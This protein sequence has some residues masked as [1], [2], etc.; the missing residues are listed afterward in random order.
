M[1][2]AA[3]ACLAV[4]L[5]SFA[6]SLQVGFLLDDFLHIDYIYRALHGSPD[7]FL[8][9]FYGNWANSPLM[10][11][12][13]PLV[14]LS[15]F[16]DYLLWGTNSF[17]FHLT[18]TLLYWACSLMVGLIALELTGMRGNRLAAAA[19]F[20]AALLFSVYPLHVESVSWVIG[21]VDLLCTFFTL[22]SV[23]CYFR[24][25][26]LRE[27][28]LF[29]I[30][31]VS[32]I[33]AVLSKEPAVVLPAV[34]TAAEFILAPFWQ[35]EVVSEFRP[36]VKT[37]R[38]TGLLS[39]W[40]VLGIYFMLRLSFLGTLVG[41]YGGSALASLKQV[42]ERGTIERILFASNLDLVKRFNYWDLQLELD[43]VLKLCYIAI[44]SIGC[45]RLL[46]G[47]A[48]RRI[49][50]FLL[51]WLLLSVLPAMQI[52]QISPNLVGSRLFFM[53][54]AP[55]T[56]LLAFLALPA[57][58]IVKK[59]Y[60]KVLSA[61][62]A[63]LLFTVLSIWSY[64]LQFDQYSWVLAHKSM[65]KLIDDV[66]RNLRQVTQDKSILFLNLPSDCSGAGLVSRA[67]Y[68]RF[69]F[70]K[71]FDDQVDTKRLVVLEAPAG[72]PDYNYS[73]VLRLDLAKGKFGR[74]L[75]WNENAGTSLCGQIFEW[76]PVSMPVIGDSQ[77]VSGAP[78][79]LY[80]YSMPGTD[81]PSDAQ[82]FEAQF[83]PVSPT[84]GK[85]WTAEEAGGRSFEKSANGALLISPGDRDLYLLFKNEQSISA[86]ELDR[87]LLDLSAR[88]KADLAFGFFWIDQSAEGEHF[89]LIDG[90][91]AA[92][93][94]K[95]EIKLGTNKRWAI[96]GQLKAFGLKIPRGDYELEFRGL[97]LCK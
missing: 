25:R 71:P 36:R 31:L 74:V 18:N 70:Q 2:F 68:L 20:W 81:S 13:R 66:K 53:A 41:G 79:N 23:F 62:G 95:T 59:Q 67:D 63:I 10:L 91:K 87:A 77:C 43:G 51:A 19:P 26:L 8:H 32:F 21:R 78:E 60:A 30:S 15:L 54:S 50:L 17:G 7:D 76:K 11:S 42:F 64:W 96:S 49:V 45:L 55:F 28:Y 39:F 82:K 86:L 29:Q 46:L 5:F 6:P 35:D 89:N 4:S 1:I 9:N 92:P 34:I 69:I 16:L 37:R 65:V 47:T 14:S 52:W 58:D 83:L 88:N 85:T 24:F 22:V 93:T 44:A 61:I 73:A 27:K 40:F 84:D 12:Y 33:A 57:I 75:Q 80:F 56:I 90:L 38:M 94:G 48:S 3:L 72:M 97:E